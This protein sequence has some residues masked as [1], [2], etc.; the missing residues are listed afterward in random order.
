MMMGRSWRMRCIL[1]SRRLVL[2]T[3][4]DAGARMTAVSIVGT[5][6]TQHVFLYQLVGMRLEKKITSIL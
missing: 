3:N 5:A 6:Q 4:L 2:R 1:L